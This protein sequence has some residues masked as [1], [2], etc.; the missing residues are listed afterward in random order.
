MRSQVVLPPTLLALVLTP[1]LLAEEATMPPPAPS[2]PAAEAPAM[3][4]GTL[5]VT[6]RRDESD[7]FLTPATVEV[8][9]DE[10]VR[11]RGRASQPE[12]LLQGLPGVEVLQTGGLGGVTSIRM[13]GALASGTVVALDG[14]PLIDPA[15]TQH[16]PD[17]GLL[18]PAGL[19]RIEVVK[20]P[21]AGVFGAD[22][23]GGV[24]N[25]LPI[26]ATP[27]HDGHLRVEAGSRAT[28]GVDGQATGPILGGLGYAVG[29]SSL[30]SHGFSSGVRVGDKGDPDGYEK[31][32][33]ARQGVYGRLDHAV[34][35]RWSTYVSADVLAAE[36]DFDSPA[37][38]Q[39]TRSRKELDSLRIQGGLAG[40]PAERIAVRGDVAHTTYDRAFPNATGA[41]TRD[42]DGDS[43]FGT[44]RV[45][46]G[47]GPATVTVGTDVR[48]DRATT[49][50]ANGAAGF[51]AEAGQ[52]GA[53]LQGVG[54]W[55]HLQIDGSVRHDHHSRDGDATTWRTG[56][57]VFPVVDRVKVYGS[58]GTAFRPPS[59]FELFEPTFGDPTL[60][61]ER[62]LGIEIGHEARAT[63]WLTFENVWFRTRY[64][65]RIDFSTA[66][67]RYGNTGEDEQVQG[68]ENAV[69]L[70]M[71]AVPVGLS[72]SYTWQEVDEDPVFTRRLAEHRWRGEL[73][74]RPIPA[75]WT[76]VT[77]DQ[78]GRRP[79]GAATLDAYTL[80][81]AAAG[82]NPVRGWEVH[83]RGSNLAGERYEVARPYGTADATIAAGASASW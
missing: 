9:D 65:E 8:I 26:R 53:W 47:A 2:A 39:D 3:P 17:I 34:T 11:V 27:T 5:V 42:F 38:P 56:L 74:W 24:V 25:L 46:A 72:V 78:V 51:S 55:D 6:A 68:I 76:A 33:F 57:A 81:G 31:D 35:E 48:R 28:Y 60:E 16:N 62:S 61:P 69:R 13:R 12:A 18:N 50:R 83:V 59:L 82:W 20:G 77:V 70:G 67:S 10:A 21:Q 29:V 32:G 45:A 66:L 52:V 19:R 36:A 22:A 63:E 49:T 54:A 41:S 15:G 75:V 79:D 7:A 40:A 37:N 4:G 73:T 30:T 64:T 44:A 14:I 80:L 1:R 23:I 71:P 58:V 43:T